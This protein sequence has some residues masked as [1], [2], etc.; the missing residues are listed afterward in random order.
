MA[1]KTR[2]AAPSPTL[3]PPTPEQ[4]SATREEFLDHSDHG[5]RERLRYQVAR[6]R[7]YADSIERDLAGLDNPAEHHVSSM[8]DL[9]AHVAD[10]EATATKIRE[11]RIVRGLF[12]PRG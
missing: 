1:T 6:L 11:R 4:T 2:S 12:K 10:M 3:T 7:E 9:A 5:D 8:R